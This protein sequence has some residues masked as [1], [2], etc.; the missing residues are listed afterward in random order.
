MRIWIT[1][2][3]SWYHIWY[4]KPT[5]HNGRFEI[6][7][8]SSV[9]KEEWGFSTDDAR[10]YGLPKLNRHECRAYELVECEP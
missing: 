5:L 7:H 8:P 9:R 2:G 1:K 6:R 3:T 10:R 4:R